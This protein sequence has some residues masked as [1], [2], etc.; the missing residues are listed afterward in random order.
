MAIS[1]W[2]DVLAGEHDVLKVFCTGED[3]TE[4]IEEKVFLGPSCLV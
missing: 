1:Q 2:P 3:S 4:L